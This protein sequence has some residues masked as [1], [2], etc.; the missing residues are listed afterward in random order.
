MYRSYDRF[1]H[2]YRKITTALLFVFAYMLVEASILIGPVPDVERMPFIDGQFVKLV[3][4]EGNRFR[5]HVNYK[6]EIYKPKAVLSVQEKEDLLKLKEGEPIKVFVYH[7]VRYPDSWIEVGK[8]EI[9]DKIIKSIR[10][11]SGIVQVHENIK[12]RIPFYLLI[13]ILTPLLTRKFL[14]KRKSEFK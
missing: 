9:N 13:L 14:K 3:R 1:W 11:Y 2:D 4:I 8:I 6:G 12:S 5:L 7:N 10:P